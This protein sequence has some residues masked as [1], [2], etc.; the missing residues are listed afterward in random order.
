MAVSVW[1]ASNNTASADSSCCLQRNTM[2]ESGLICGAWQ[3]AS[4]EMR[5]SGF[6]DANVQIYRQQ[7]SD[8]H[9]LHLLM[10]RGFKSDCWSSDSLTDTLKVLKDLFTSGGT[11]TWPNGGFALSNQWRPA[12][13][14]P[15]SRLRARS[16]ITDQSQTWTSV[17]NMWATFPDIRGRRRAPGTT[18]KI[19]AL[20]AFTFCAGRCLSQP[21][22]SHDCT[23][24]RKTKTPCSPAVKFIQNRPAVFT[25]KTCHLTLLQVNT[26]KLREHRSLCL[27][28]LFL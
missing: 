3:T 21:A 11:V 27:W 17:Q 7:L 18:C 4:S 22:Q 13:S 1:R 20:H 2:S 19:A 5:H 26:V 6:K 14:A 24:R 28:F 16:Q 25:H 23:C 15:R 12:E 8:S 9:L 10:N